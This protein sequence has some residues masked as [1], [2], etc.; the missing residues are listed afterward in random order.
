MDI[1]HNGPTKRLDPRHVVSWPVR[2]H[3]AD[4]FSESPFLFKC[5]IRNISNR[6]AY[7]V[8]PLDVRIGEHLRMELDLLPDGPG[9]VG[10]RLRCDAE[11]LRKE[12]LPGGT[13]DKA[14]AI[15]VRILGYEPPQI[16]PASPDG[17][18]PAAHP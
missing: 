15:G 10:V 12:A 4:D 5:I 9:T 11:V 1:P 3:Y 8:G 16:T 14:F 6:G 18:S 7:I 17:D 13:T 2:I